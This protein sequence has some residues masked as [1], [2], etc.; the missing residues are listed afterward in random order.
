MNMENKRLALKGH[1]YYGHKVLELLESFGAA[2]SHKFTGNYECN[3]FYIENGTILCKSST[4][5]DE[6]NIDMFDIYTYEEFCSKYP[7]MVGDI[8]KYRGRSNYVIGGLVWNSNTVKY[9][10]A[11]PHL[12]MPTKCITNVNASDLTKVVPEEP[13]RLGEWQVR[14][15]GFLNL[16]PIKNVLKNLESDRIEIDIPD[17]YELKI[18]DGKSYFVKTQSKYAQDLDD[19]YRILG[20]KKE[21]VTNVYNAFCSVEPTFPN[22]GLLLMYRAAFYKVIGYEPSDNVDQKYCIFN[23]GGNVYMDLRYTKLNFI[24]S[25]PTKEDCNK[26][27]ELYYKVIESCKQFI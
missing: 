25:F 8:V 6:D 21:N 13:I 16:E 19:C 18:E 14:N 24:L 7:L 22:L 17:G 5:V 15:S 26:F 23:N 11:T 9:N 10:L 20:I 2:N 4:F 3:I 27:Y 1:P 12:D